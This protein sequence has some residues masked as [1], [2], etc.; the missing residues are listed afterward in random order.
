VTPGGEVLYANAAG[1]NLMDEFCHNG[2]VVSEEVQGLI[3]EAVENGESVQVE[4]TVDHSVFILSFVPRKED[5]NVNIYGMDL[6]S[7]IP[8]GGEHNFSEQLLESVADAELTSAIKYEHKRVK[9]TRLR[10]LGTLAS[11]MAHDLRNPLTVIETALYNIRRKRINTDIDRHLDNIQKKLIESNS[12]IDN[13][14]YFSRK[15]K[16]FP[17]ECDLHDI[18][19]DSIDTSLTRFGNEKI[20]VCFQIDPVKGKKLKGD[21]C[22]LK[23]VFTNLLNN[24]FQ[25]LEGKGGHISAKAFFSKPSG[26]VVEISDNG[27][28]IEEEKIKDIFKPFFTTKKKGTGLGLNIC[29]DI[30]KAHKGGLHIESRISGGTKVT[31]KLPAEVDKGLSS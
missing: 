31:V 1:K 10:K 21:P 17:V 3:E 5:N 2:R 22:Q 12:I 7:C 4:M 28:G 29:R 24:S 16:V 6:S 11:Q 13:I 20:D 14:L 15:K 23:Q 9:S 26:A 8:D 18:I 19:T 27:N 30:I 25:A